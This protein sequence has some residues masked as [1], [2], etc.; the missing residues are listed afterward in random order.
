MVAAKHKPTLNV[1]IYAPFLQGFYFGELINQLQLKCLENGHNFHLINSR[2]FGQFKSKILLEKLDAVILLRN[3]VHS[4]LVKTMLDRGINVVSIAFD[5]FPLDVPSVTCDNEYGIELA[6]KH[7]L[8]KGHKQFVYIGD[9]SQFDLRKRYEAFCDQHEFHGFNLDDKHIFVVDNTLFSGGQQVAG[10]F[11]ERGIGARGVICGAGL[12]AIGFSQQLGKLNPQLRKDMDIVAFD[13][14]P[15]I[16]F[17]APT[18]SVIDQNLNQIAD[19]AIQIIEDAHNGLSTNAQ[20]SVQPRLIVSQESKAKSPDT[21]DR[22]TALSTYCDPNYLKSLLCN[23]YEWPTEIGKHRLEN[24]MMLEPVFPNLLQAVYFT[25]FIKD[26]LGQEYG[27]VIRAITSDTIISYKKAENENTTVL[28]SYP[29][30]IAP[31]NTQQFNLQIHVPV[32][33]E[34]EEWGL[35]SVFGGMKDDEHPASLTAFCGYLAHIVNNLEFSIGDEIKVSKPLATHVQAGGAQSDTAGKIRWNYDEHRTTWDSTA[36]TLLGITSELEL[37]IYCNMDL[38]D[39]IHPDDEEALRAMMENAEQEGTRAYLRLRHKN[40]SY[41]AYELYCVRDEE[42]NE[43]IC[44]IEIAD[45]DE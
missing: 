12:T 27:R 17:S 8:D 4:E 43:F 21:H 11:I 31:V 6:F 41:E 30:T 33:F 19:E 45:K 14:I 18:V 20:V 5:Y 29:Q 39:R 24:I 42:A 34:G 2:G 16:S 40:K 26:N 22:K 7:L 9:L 10:E 37:S 1:G 44:S 3:A 13:A 38:T 23:F 32:V 15:L 25:R 35:V 28:E 36:L